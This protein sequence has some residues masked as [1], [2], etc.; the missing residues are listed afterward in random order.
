MFG[1]M[2]ENTSCNGARASLKGCSQKFDSTR[3]LGWTRAL[4]RAHQTLVGALE[5]ERAA[6]IKALIGTL[7]LLLDAVLALS[8][9]MK[10]LAIVTGSMA[11]APGPPL[12][13]FSPFPP[14]LFSLRCIGQRRTIP[15]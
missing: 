14:A 3:G 5:A 10:V 15:A 9:V 13:F 2:E 11:L 7:S 12:D 1:Y 4:R 8:D 6:L